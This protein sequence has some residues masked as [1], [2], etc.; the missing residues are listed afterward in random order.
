MVGKNNKQAL[1]QKA[2]Q[3][4]HTYALRKFSFGVASVAVGTFFG[5]SQSAVADA[6]VNETWVPM[7]EISAGLTADDVDWSA[8]EESAD[9]ETETAQ[10]EEETD[11]VMTEESKDVQS[12][13]A[14]TEEITTD[15][16]V[17]ASD[18]EKDSEAV[19]VDDND[20]SD[21]KVSTYASGPSN[22]EEAADQYIEDEDGPK[23]EQHAIGGI[24][25]LE[26]VEDNRFAVEYETGEH[27]QLYFYDDN[28][29]R[30]YMDPEGEFADPAPRDPERPARIEEK[31]FDAFDKFKVNL[32]EN[33]DQYI[34]STNAMSVELDKKKGTMAIFNANHEAVA[35]EVEPLKW[36]EDHATQTLKANEKDQFFGGGTQNGRFTH[37]GDSIEIR[38]T[39]NWVDGGVA[40]PNPFYWSYD[41]DKAYGVLR[42]TFTKGIYDFEDSKAGQVSTTHDEGRFDAFYFVGEKPADILKGY[43][44]ITGTP[45]VLPE[46]AHYQGHL[47]AYNR[48]Y[49]VKLPEN[50]PE[51]YLSQAITFDDREGYWIEVNP[52]TTIPQ[53]AQ[54]LR[55]E[56]YDS[57]SAEEKQA[58][59]ME[60]EK[61]AAEQFDKEME[62]A[63]G[64]LETLNGKPTDDN[65]AF[66]AR[67]LI[68]R[69][70]RYDMPIGW[71]LVNDGYGAGYGQEPTLAGNIQNLKEFQQWAKEK[72]GIETGLWTESDLVPDET[73]EALL[74]RDL[75][76][77]V[78]EAGVRILKTDVAWVGA[79]YSFGLNGTDIAKEVMEKESNGDRPFIIT[80][81]GWGGT[82]RNGGIWTGD[83]QGGQWEYIRF[84]I[85]TYIGTG[86]SGQPN[87]ASD[88]DGIYG[89]KDPIINTRDYQWKTFTSMQ[90][91]MDGWGWNP[92]DPF[93]FDDKTTDINR[94][95]L[96]LKSA[97]LPYAY[98]IHHEAT[99]GLPPIRAMFLEYPDE[100]INYTTD[101]QYQYMYGS[102]FL[103]API[104]QDTN[105]DEAGNDIRNGIVL[106]EGD[107]WIDFFTGDVYE[108]G[109]VL[110]NFDAPVWK[111]PVFVRQGAI[112]PINKPNNSVQEI[113]RGLRMVDFYPA[114]DSEFTLIEDDGR[115]VDYREGAVAKTQITSHVDEDGNV[116]LTMG[117]TNGSFDGYQAEKQAQ[118][119]VNATAKPESLK[120]FIGDHEVELTAV[121]SLEAFENGENV[122]FYDAEPNLNQFSYDSE[123]ADKAV[124]KNPVIR[125]KSEAFDT[126]K[127]DV[128]LEI[129]GYEYDQDHFKAVSETTGDK[130]TFNIDGNPTTPTS[131]TVTWDA[132]EDADRYELE[133]DGVR[134]TNLKDTTFNHND[135][136]YETAH[137]YR[138]RALRSDNT[139]TP[140]SDVLTM[141]TR[142]DPTFY[143][144]DAEHVTAE[145]DKPD[146]KGEEIDFLVDGD[147][148]TGYHSQYNTKAT[149]EEITFTFDDVFELD[150]LQYV[151]RQSGTNGIITKAT[152][153]YS[154]DGENFTDIETEIEWDGDNKVKVFELGGIKA[155]AIKLTVSE[156]VG[157]FVS[158]QELSFLQVTG[159]DDTPAPTITEAPA[160]EEETPADKPSVDEGWVEDDESDAPTVNEEW[161]DAEVQSPVVKEEWIDDDDSDITAEWVDTDV[162]ASVDDM[163]HEDVEA[164]EDTIAT[165]HTVTTEAEA[166]AS[167]T[168][169][170]DVQ[171]VA[172]HE[173]T[174][175]QTGVGMAGLGI[176]LVLSGIG[177]AFAFKKRD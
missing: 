17:V 125:V 156:A 78:G 71:I 7:S 65:Y 96:K 42:N 141:T 166:A 54:Q 87:I 134:Y 101:V 152:V 168:A 131:A 153:S 16:E 37:K 108:G 121:D 40:S 126:T 47:N 67:G 124:I 44:E 142:K 115:T 49:W 53:I 150:K 114:G 135:L 119:N 136:D 55:P 15:E 64:I 14:E 88:M 93:A 66:T 25:K 77:E 76:A 62:Q 10:V 1:K 169:A 105:S 45:V 173:A 27:G 56:N 75:A 102:D 80:L 149:P 97:L 157:D 104:Y 52:L 26:Q 122:Y 107:N 30:F 81:D 111:L 143:I 132:V 165:D 171:T 9:A 33:Q 90:L 162:E 155:K 98:T 86:L 139:A 48:D 164:S 69:Y 74:Q 18:A 89:G 116:V 50:T 8:V 144:V 6:S 110:N 128:R 35:E 172:N 133:V 106:P 63:G 57:L 84:H 19:E 20:K 130:P 32:K 58:I 160:E 59:D 176:G 3:K 113:D 21:K 167:D 4:N 92:K 94:S 174:L 117:K 151:P 91:N 43:Y 158:G 112:I 5:L 95:Y 79:G 23:A 83:Q 22:G 13:I 137:T 120:L 34:L 99:E 38:N 145:A 100:A 12:E 154:E 161:V 123:L 118:F 109:Q 140:W 146:Q 73:K 163:V 41:G 129:G 70:H 175:P 46:F 24:T 103:V 2:M 31:E 36:S 72:Y 51:E 148:S 39:N 82:Q 60:N 28:I 159:E 170:Q 29:V 68:D 177:S 11:A 61:I 85:P 138:V 127:E 147:I